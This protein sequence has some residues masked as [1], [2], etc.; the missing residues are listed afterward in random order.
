VISPSQCRYLTQTQN[1]HR[2]TRMPRVGFE[3]MFSAFERV[4]TVHVLDRAATVIGLS[5]L[6]G[7]K[8]KSKSRY[9]LRSVG[10][11]VL[12]SSPIWGPKIRFFY[13]QTVAGL[14]T[15][16]ALSDERTGLSFT[17]TA[18]SHQ[19]SHSRVRVNADNTVLHPNN[20]VIFICITVTTSISAF[21]YGLLNDAS[22]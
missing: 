8:I 22:N 20:T 13:C 12:V 4:K 2:Q 11:S 17:I 19:R 3:P 6:T 21:I 16:S 10:Q 18:G 14:L 15:W 7:L 1:K 9:D 5:R